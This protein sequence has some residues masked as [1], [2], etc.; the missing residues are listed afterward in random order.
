MASKW[1]NAGVGYSFRIVPADNGSAIRRA[2]VLRRRGADRVG[3]WIAPGPGMDRR[4]PLPRSLHPRSAWNESVHCVRRGARHGCDDHGVEFVGG[5]WVSLSDGQ[6]SLVTHGVTR[7]QVDS[8]A[9]AP[10]TP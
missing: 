7:F 9:N 5:G 10:K 8:A 3:L 4:R 6:G 2:A 1:G